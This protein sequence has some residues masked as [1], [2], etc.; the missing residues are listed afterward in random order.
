MRLKWQ[1]I[2]VLSL[3]ITLLGLKLFQ[4]RSNMLYRY[5]DKLRFI[6]NNSF[7]EASLD[8]I[9]MIFIIHNLHKTSTK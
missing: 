5:H 3:P 6:S 7:R 1:H 2:N 8:N 9:E 4:G